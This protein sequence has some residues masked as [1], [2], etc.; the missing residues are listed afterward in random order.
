MQNT[1]KTLFTQGEEHL[2]DTEVFQRTEVCDKIYNPEFAL[3]TLKMHDYV[4]ISIVVDG[5]G[6]H[7]MM[8]ETTECCTGDMYILSKGIPHGYFAKSETERPTVR[9]I[10]FKAT[11][12]FNGDFSDFNSLKFCYGVFRDKIPV[13][14]AMLTSRTLSRLE[15]IFSAIDREVQQKEPMWQEA[16]KGHL[17]LLMITV[18]RYINMAETVETKHPKDWITVSAAMKE[19]LEHFGDTEMTLESIASSLFISKSHLSRLFQKVTGESFID[20]VRNVRINRAC[21]LL[22]G[23]MMTNS[24]IVAECGLKDVPSFYRLFRT[25]VG[26][27]PYQYR[28][29]NKKYF[30]DT[31]SEN[32]LYEISEKLQ[33]GNSKSL[34]ELVIKALESGIS[35]VDILEKGLIRGMDSIGKRFKNNEVYVPEV[36]VAARAMNMVMKILKPY[37]AKDGIRSRGRVCIGTVQ[38]DLHDI[39]KNLVKLMM[40]GKGIEVIDLG[41]DVSPETYIKAAIE[42]KCKIICCSALLTTTMDV[43]GDVVKECERAGIRDKVKIMIGGAPI[44]KEFCDGIGAD[45]YTDDAASAAE[46]AVRFLSEYNSQREM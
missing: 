2:N 43:I 7:R 21:E 6:I 16:V 18:A 5:I 46:A 10:L 24:E 27:T 34:E 39:G 15:E 30:D 22:R 29:S 23:T 19:V 32:M 12:L 31:V 8:N 14:Y 1:E 9:T 45:C 28:M 13:S 25:V 38:G 3:S 35:V 4:E 26:M 17:V 42:N 37:I 11:E 40:E 33:K 41:T 44:T 20:Y 36:M